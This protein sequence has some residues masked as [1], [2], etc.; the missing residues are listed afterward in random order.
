MSHLPHPQSIQGPAIGTL[1][2][3][4]S[5]PFASHPAPGPPLSTTPIPP[6]IHS[7][8]TVAATALRTHHLRLLL[9]CP[10]PLSSLAFSGSQPCH[11]AAPQTKCQHPTPMSAAYAAKANN[12]CF[13][14]P[15][16][17]KPNP[18][19]E[20]PPS[21]I[22]GVI[23]LIRTCPDT[24]G[25]RLNPSAEIPETLGQAN[26]C[27]SSLVSAPYRFSKCLLLMA[28]RAKPEEM[29]AASGMMMRRGSA[30]GDW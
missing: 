2:N 5:H 29:C 17:T 10:Y 23:L 12:G 26:L 6:A 18:T 13:E 4:S 7:P 25:I 27:L 3:I 9:L 20:L 15:W 30:S 1:A 24:N 11:F 16:L 21:T 19:P 22:K 28:R 14:T 8:V